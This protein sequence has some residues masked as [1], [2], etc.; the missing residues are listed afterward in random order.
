[1]N[2]KEKE[3]S[4]TLADHY[5]KSKNYPLA[6]AMLKKVIARDPQSPKANELLAYIYGN[7]GNQEL[8]HNLLIKACASN[9]ASAEAHYYLGASY[10][11]LSEFKKA[12][13]SLKQALD[14]AGDFFEGLHDIGITEAQLGNNQE[15]LKYFSKALNLRKNSHELF[16]NI[17]R[18]N[19]DLKDYHAAANNYDQAI[20]LKPDF[21]EAWSNKGITLNELKRFEE[22]LAHFDQAIRLKPD[23]VEAWSNKGITLNK[24]KRFEEALAHYDQAIQLKPDYAE[25]WSNKG[26]TLNELKRF[27]EALAHYHQAIQLKPDYAEAWSNKGLTLHKLNRFDDAITHYDQAIRVEP[28]YVDAIS[29]KGQALGD[30][31]QYTKAINAFNKAMAIDPNYTEAILNKSL[32]NLLLKNYEDGWK[33]YESRLIT[34]EFKFP[35][36]TKTLPIWDGRKEIDH[37]LLVPEQGIGDEIFYNALLNELQKK[38]AKITVL[39]DKRITQILIRSFPNII[40]LEKGSSLDNHLFDA[41]LAIGSIPVALNTRPQNNYFPQRSFLKPN[42]DL[43]NTIKRIE[44]FN[45]KFVCGISWKSVNKELGGSKSLNLSELMPILNSPNCSFVNLQYGDVSED[46]KTIRE[47][48]GVIISKIPEIDLYE[49]IDGLLSMID[50]CNVV[51]TTCNITAHLAG[52]I[53]KKTFLLAPYSQGRIW[54]WH[55]DEFNAWYPS[56]KQYFQDH[57]FSWTSAITKIAKELELEVAGEN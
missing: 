7:Q 22:A 26:I 52:A 15:A 24:L 25:A 5:F 57:N 28:D 32:I 37:L 1:M 16:F 33:N 11:K 23:Y 38:V 10:I 43:S 30:L 40:F 45:K 6:E 47:K 13:K 8:A 12:N 20:Q 34:N 9:D 49:N 46:I 18:T 41:Q 39:S 29:N 19:D 54:Y 50:S 44:A 42:S 17:A 31:H 53:G 2:N 3:Q 21:A 14:Q 48:Y 35:I 36:S 4:L 51:I 56:I 55:D 27:E